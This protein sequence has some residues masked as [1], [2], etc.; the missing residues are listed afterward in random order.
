MCL[1]RD[2]EWTL[3]TESISARY[4]DLDLWPTVDAV[5]AMLDAQ[6]EAVDAVGSQTGAIARAAEEAAARLADPKGRLIYIGA[7]TSGRL[8]VQ[9]GVELGPTYDWAEARTA[10]LLAGGAAAVMASVEG[11]E[12]NIAAGEQAMAGAA[13]G[14]GDVVIAV[15]ASGTTPFT[16]AAARAGAA[17]GALT[18][19]IA[20]N[21]GSPLLT[22]VAQPIV[23]DTGA[24]VIAGSTRMKAG[25]AQK[26]ALNLLSTAVMLRLGRVYNGLMVNMRLSNDKLRRRAIEM[27]GEIAGVEKAA[28]A[29]ALEQAGGDIRLAALIA[30][31]RTREEGASA[32]DAAAGN[33]R[34]AIGKA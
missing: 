34:V 13:P 17:A 27:V 8:A 19:G 33:L 10:Y 5:A 29:A 32:L 2:E 1:V 30:L 15:S 22:L 16:V 18:I 4:A 23:L 3:S 12:D 26:I 28:A 20:S 6:R 21:A 25:T 24:E 14:A 11:A 31:G 9:D 7:G